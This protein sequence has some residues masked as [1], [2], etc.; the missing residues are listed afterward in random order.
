MCHCFDSF[1]RKSVPFRCYSIVFDLNEKS[2]TWITKELEQLATEKLV[3]KNEYGLDGEL[4]EKVKN[5][6]NVFVGPIEDNDF[7]LLDNAEKRKSWFIGRDMKKK[8][9]CYNFQL[10]TSYKVLAQHPLHSKQN[11][12]HEMLEYC[13]ENVEY[14]KA[15]TI[16]ELV[17]EKLM[18][19][20]S[21]ESLEPNCKWFYAEMLVKYYN[22]VIGTAGRIK[23]MAAVCELYDELCD[24]KYIQPN[25]I[26]FKNVLFSCAFSGDVQKFEYYFQLFK[27]KKPYNQQIYQGLMY[28][29]FIQNDYKKI[30]EI[31]SEMKKFNVNIS[32]L[33][34][35]I[36]LISVVSSSKIEVKRSLSLIRSILDDGIAR[37]P[38]NKQSILIS[39]AINSSINID[40]NLAFTILQDYSTQTGFK[41]LNHTFT[42]MM[43]GIVSSKFLDRSAIVSVWRH[44]CLTNLRFDA[45][46]LDIALYA[47]VTSG[48]FNVCQEIWDYYF[49]SNLKNEIPQ[50]SLIDV[51]RFY[52][53]LMQYVAHTGDLEKAYMLLDHVKESGVIPRAS[54]YCNFLRCF[55]HRKNCQE[56][57]YDA[58]YILE[59]IFQEHYNSRNAEIESLSFFNI[60]LRA[61]LRSNRMDAFVFVFKKLKAAKIQVKPGFAW[62]KT[63]EF[64]SN[65]L[66]KLCFKFF[67]FRGKCEFWREVFDYFFYVS[68]KCLDSPLL[69]MEKANIGIKFALREAQLLALT[70]FK[71]YRDKNLFLKALDNYKRCWPIYRELKGF[72]FR[73][74]QRYC[75]MKN[76]RRLR[77][78]RRIKSSYKRRISHYSR[79]KTTSNV[80]Y[81]KKKPYLS[82]GNI[83]QNEIQHPEATNGDSEI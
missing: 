75:N 7:N 24:M 18:L 43:M 71:Q 81:R 73:V 23:N 78:R 58:L 13:F 50:S 80:K 52:T 31:Y 74:I 12:L 26:T 22:F 1:D 62:Y 29:S 17:K 40:V 30:L 11:Q 57:R 45:L 4:L 47:A 2:G 39:H 3:Q 34:I 63:N 77:L 37:L 54:F 21:E 42:K 44:A 8:D 67:Y 20:L 64:M 6:L 68:E 35:F 48:H 9:N 46:S 19:K 56:L 53:K 33:D 32:S 82:F 55:L 27:L 49:S 65:T 79:L 83:T 70:F 38:L 51:E 28:N 66:I 72:K 36:M 76:F 16:L 61:A 5:A 60:A 15:R 25:M 59:N 41:L 10:Q 69:K 14:G